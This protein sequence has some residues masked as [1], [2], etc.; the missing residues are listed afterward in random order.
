[1]IASYS[2]MPRGERIG[3][4]R[5]PNFFTTTYVAKAIKATC[6]HFMIFAPMKK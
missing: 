5:L 4:R 3:F 1:M 6:H 2:V